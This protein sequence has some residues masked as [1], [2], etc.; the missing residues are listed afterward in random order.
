M[1]T[2]RFQNFFILK[3]VSLL[4]N[5]R[6]SGCALLN[7]NSFHKDKRSTTSG[8]RNI[9]TILGFSAAYYLATKNKSSNFINVANCSTVHNFKLREKFNFIADVVENAGDAVVYI[10]IID[11]R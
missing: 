6:I 11:P 7:S 4:A 3:H 1:L 9:A 2:K 5:N 8:Y 10:E